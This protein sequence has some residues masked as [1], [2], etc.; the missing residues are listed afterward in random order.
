MQHEPELDARVGQRDVD[1]PGFGEPQ[2]TADVGMLI[3]VKDAPVLTEGRPPAPA[4]VAQVG[5]LAGR[6]P[7]HQPQGRPVKRGDGEVRPLA[8]QPVPVIS[9]IEKIRDR[10]P[11]TLG[12]LSEALDWPENHLDNILNRHLKPGL[13]TPEHPASDLTP[14]EKAFLS[15]G[16][17]LDKLNGKLDALLKH[18]D[19]VWQPGEPSGTSIDLAGYDHAHEPPKPED[20]A[21]AP[22]ANE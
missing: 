14:A 20:D 2:R 3:D 11:G 6:G 17:K 10:G 5:G 19:I 8:V 4:G 16:E 15:F 13:A 12:R 22:T 9:E 18:Y 1:L 21:P 7:L